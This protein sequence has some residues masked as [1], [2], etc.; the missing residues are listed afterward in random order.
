MSYAI[1]TT[2]ANDNVEPYHDRQKAVPRREKRM[3][4]LDLTRPEEELLRPLPAGS[5]R[6]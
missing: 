5:F 4:W 2:T 3:D 1:L 6:V